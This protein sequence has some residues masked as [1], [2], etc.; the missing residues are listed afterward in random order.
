M[1]IV[2]CGLFLFD[3]IYFISFGHIFLRVEE[4][5][6][7]QAKGVKDGAENLGELLMGDRIENSPYRFMMYTNVS[8]I[9]LCKSNPLSADEFKIMKERIDDIFSMIPIFIL[10]EESALLCRNFIGVA[11]WGLNRW[12]EGEFG[13]YF[14]FKREMQRLNRLVESVLPVG[15]AGRENEDGSPPE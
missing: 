1:A 10:D 5:S 7:D 9:F 3:K 14:G 8:E 12:G 13:F 4:K 15:L 11:L 2:Y 6:P